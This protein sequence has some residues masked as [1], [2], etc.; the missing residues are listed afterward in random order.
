MAEG[1]AEGGGK[2]PALSSRIMQMKFMQRG[3]GKAADQE[4]AKDQVYLAGPLFHRCNTTEQSSRLIST[5][6]QATVPS[7]GSDMA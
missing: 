2:K 4:A 3:K 1:K 5:H 6:A 7:L